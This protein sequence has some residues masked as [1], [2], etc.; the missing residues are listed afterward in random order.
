MVDFY[1]INRDR[2]IAANVTKYR[3]TTSVLI[4]RVSQSH[5]PLHYICGDGWVNGYGWI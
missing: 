1:F 5:R 3:L 2:Q 4:G